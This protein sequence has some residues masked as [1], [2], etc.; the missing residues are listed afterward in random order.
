[1]PGTMRSTGACK[2]AQGM[3]GGFCS[4]NAGWNLVSVISLQGVLRKLLNVLLCLSLPLISKRMIA[5][6]F[7]KVVVRIKWSDLCKMFRMVSGT[8]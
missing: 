2:I 8:Q 5:F 3:E 4:Q 7:H 1:M 6:L